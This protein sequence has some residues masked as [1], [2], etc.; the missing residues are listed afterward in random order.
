MMG[1]RTYFFLTHR[2]KAREKTTM[3]MGSSCSGSC[4]RRRRPLP[5][6]SWLALVSFSLSTLQHCHSFV[7]TTTTSTNTI[8]NSKTNSSRRTTAFPECW[9]T[10]RRFPHFE[11]NTGTRLRSLA[12]SSTTAT[13]SDAVVVSTPI[14]VQQQQQQQQHQGEPSATTTPPPTATQLRDELVALAG[15]LSTSNATQ[16]ARIEYL[17]NTLET[18]YERPLTV[19]FFKTVAIMPTWRLI[20]STSQLT[21][22]STN[23]VSPLQ[24]RLRGITQRGGDD[25]PVVDPRRKK[26]DTTLTTTV[27]WDYAEQADGRFGCSG[28]FALRTSYRM[29]PG[30]TRLQ[31]IVVSEND[32]TTPPPVLRLAKGSD[33]PS[34]VS[35]IVALLRR[36]VPVELFE[37][38]SSSHVVEAV[39]VT[40]VDAHVKICRYSGG[41]TM[42][43]GVRNVYVRQQQLGPPL[44]IATTTK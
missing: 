7:V 19:D 44:P 17:I 26:T 32:T 16:I 10:K 9:S 23:H 33:L 43:E 20:L 24:F 30:S 4:S 12:S 25:E 2:K 28:T 15:C 6:L 41:G 14:K 22:K 35:T 21:S 11:S 42:M 13:L 37:P 36:S 3:M 38:V 8:A 29:P 18:L 34:D 27:A 5:L 40:Y 39:D 1:T 31:P